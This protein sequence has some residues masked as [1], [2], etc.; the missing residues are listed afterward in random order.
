[1]LHISIRNVL[2]VR[3]VAFQIPDV[4]GCCSMDSG[5][6]FWIPDLDFCETHVFDIMNFKTSLCLNS[7]TR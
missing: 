6:G 3:F 2:D 5:A 1:M 4:A 7:I